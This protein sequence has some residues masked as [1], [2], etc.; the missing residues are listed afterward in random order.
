MGLNVTNGLT[1]MLWPSSG[2]SY[3]EA[4]YEHVLLVPTYVFLCY[5]DLHEAHQQVSLEVTNWHGLVLVACFL[6]T[7]I[8]HPG[9]SSLVS[10]LRHYSPGVMWMWMAYLRGSLPGLDLH[11]GLFSYDG[12]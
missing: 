10:Q 5:C 7:A 11:C 4:S 1:G 9:I 8:Q 6:T 2:R 3:I 12:V